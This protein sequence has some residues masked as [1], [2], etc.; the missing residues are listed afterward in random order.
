MQT[1]TM[2]DVRKDDV[3]QTYQVGLRTWYLLA[4][5]SWKSGFSLIDPLV[6]LTVITAIYWA[7]S[8]QV[9]TLHW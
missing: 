1:Y 9:Q 2:E 8:S 4:V 5:Q 6:M 3:I 7:V